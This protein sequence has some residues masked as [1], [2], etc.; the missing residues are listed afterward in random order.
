MMLVDPTHPAARAERKPLKHSTLAN[1]TDQTALRRRIH[2]TACDAYVSPT[3]CHCH[4]CNTCIEGFD[5]HCIYL[6]VCIGSRNYRLFVA[7]LCCT[8]MLLTTQLLVT[9]FA[10][11]HRQTRHRT[12]DLSWE[13]VLLIISL[14]MLPLLQLL[15]LM[16]LG[17][18]H[19]YIAYRGMRTHEWLQQFRRR[20]RWTTDRQAGDASD[21]I[22]LDTM[23]SQKPIGDEDNRSCA[24]AVSLLVTPSTD[25]AIVALEQQQ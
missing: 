14:S 11:H 23:K 3:T 20:H 21:S 17:C 16:V 18:F 5:H 19:L 2:C 15:C 1:A 7:L 4:I 6:N 8:I 10:L 25:R 9:G 12:P 22:D 24:P 13:M